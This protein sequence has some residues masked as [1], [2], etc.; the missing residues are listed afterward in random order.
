[1]AKSGT[2]D[3]FVAYVAAAVVIVLVSIFVLSWN[4]VKSSG[5]DVAYVKVGPYR[6]DTQAFALTAT[7]SVQM[8]AGNEDWAND[9]RQELNIIFKKVLA[10]SDPS[11]IKAPNR[12]ELLQKALTKAAN[13]A[14]HTNVV[15]AVLVTDFTSEIHTP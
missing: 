12:L 1:M 5:S 10:E 9:H 13:S 7:L 15:Q 14:M 6:V 3:N 8:K 2:Q 4:H 11:V